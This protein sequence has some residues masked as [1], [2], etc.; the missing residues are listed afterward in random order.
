MECI[1]REWVEEEVQDVALF[2]P[3]TS[4]VA[5][6]LFN[7]FT[8]MTLVPWPDVI[9]PLLAGATV[10]VKVVSGSAG[11]LYV[12]EANSQFGPKPSVMV[13]LGNGFTV[14]VNCV[15]DEPWHPLL[16]K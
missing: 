8:V 10:H 2:V 16:L 12:W 15:A 13:V 5:G 4:I 6:P 9:V 7:Q 1:V 11:T 14:T 3:V